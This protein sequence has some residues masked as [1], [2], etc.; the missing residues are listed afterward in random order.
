MRIL[1]PVFAVGVSALIAACGGGGT[2]SIAPPLGP[3][4]GAPV[5][6]STGALSFVITIPKKLSEQEVFA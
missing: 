3:N 5:P 2:S 4:P 1:R 6:G